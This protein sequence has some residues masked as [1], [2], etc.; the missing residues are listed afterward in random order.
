MSLRTSRIVLKWIQRLRRR[1]T[2]STVSK[3]AKALERAEKRRLLLDQEMRH[4]L[5]LIK[6]LQQRQE[7]LQHRILE[8]T[9]L[10][11]PQANSL[12]RVPSLEE[13]PLRLLEEPI[14]FSPT[15]R[16]FLQEPT[17]D[18]TPPQ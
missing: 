15:L 4:Q 8:L 13:I 1:S 9:P 17:K 7:Q 18:S 14:N 5:L 11:P 6:E 16:A 10:S 12:E 2:W 3:T